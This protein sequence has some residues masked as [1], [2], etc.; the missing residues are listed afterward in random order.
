MPK[1]VYLQAI[2]NTNLLIDMVEDFTLDN[3]LK[4]PTLYGDNMNNQWKQLIY[5]CFNNKLKNKELKL[6][7]IVKEKCK[8][9]ITKVRRCISSFIW[10]SR[11]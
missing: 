5:D 10:R 3:S 8:N 7:S 6:P 11:K 9:I 4:Y 2:N 1:D